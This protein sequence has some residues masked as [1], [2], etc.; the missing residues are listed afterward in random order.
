ML[1]LVHSIDQSQVVCTFFAGYTVPRG[2][3]D[4]AQMERHRRAYLKRFDRR[5]G[6]ASAFIVWKKEPHKSGTVH[7]HALIF[8]VVPEPRLE[9]FRRWNDDAWAETVKSPNPH[10]RRV[11]CRVELMQSWSGVGWYCAK[12]LA[13]DWIGVDADTG[14]I[15]GVHNRHLLARSIDVQHVP[16]LVGV[17]MQR[18]LRKLQRRRRE[19]WWVQVEGHWIPIFSGRGRLPVPDQVSMAKRM[20]HRVKRFRPTCLVTTERSVWADVIESNG[21]RS[22]VRSLECLGTERHAFAS[23]LHFIREDTARRLLTWSMDLWLAK[24]EAPVP[25]EPQ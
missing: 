12:Y 20:G 3:A 13:K 11:G 21:F 4:W 10:H 2:E 5:W 7:L 8:W 9:D 17:Q 18:Q 1:G 14:R 16:P 24:L 25:G 6:D 19:R 15:W 22:G 23:S